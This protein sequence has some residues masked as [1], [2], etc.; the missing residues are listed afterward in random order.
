MRDA[1]YRDGGD[2]FRSHVS[3]ASNVAS[4]CRFLHDVGVVRL[5]RRICALQL[6][7]LITR[8]TR[9]QM[10]R[11]LKDANVLVAR[12]PSGQWNA[13]LTDF[14]T[15]AGVRFVLEGQA[16]GTLHAMAPELMQPFGVGT[17]AVR[18]D[19]RAADVYAYGILL[20]ALWDKGKKPLRHIPIASWAMVR[21]LAH[22]GRQDRTSILLRRLMCEDECIASLPDVHKAEGLRPTPPVDMPLYFQGLMGRCLKRKP[23]DRP[24]FFS[25]CEEFKAKFPKP[26]APEGA[27]RAELRVIAVVR[28]RTAQSS[29]K[30][31]LVHVTVTVED[32]SKSFNPGTSGDVDGGGDAEVVFPFAVCEGESV[33]FSIGNDLELPEDRRL[34]HTKAFD[35][36]GFS[37]LPLPLPAVG[38]EPSTIDPV[39][40]ELEPKWSA[41]VLPNTTTA[42]QVALQLNIT[43]RKPSGAEERRSLGVITVLLTAPNTLSR[44]YTPHRMPRELR[45]RFEVA[46]YDVMLSYREAETGKFGSNFVFR[47]QEALELKHLTVFCYANLVNAPDCWMSP[48]SNGIAACRVFMPI[49]SPEYG[50]LDKAPWAAAELFHAV[51]R[52]GTK[53]GPAHIL[54]VWHSGDCPPSGPNEDAAKLLASFA[55][56]PDRARFDNT[57]ARNMRYKDVWLIVHDALK[58]L[59]D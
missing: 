2:N 42:A 22:L 3:V 10:H 11:D 35:W 5:P 57:P 19:V 48:L 54:P 13:K 32:R 31:L 7:P 17:D 43:R 16:V 45:S 55:C 34:P 37:R 46:E 38:A 52:L 33:L 20:C 8:F 15:S 25:I 28:Y 30:K 36:A 29:A 24:T 26:P 51:S 14:G 21:H 39:E 12:S 49:L 44:S 1:F 47:L 58:H 41:A 4:A 23:H 50:N 6:A 59:L 27:P 9:P 40:F 18:V 56:V 53:D